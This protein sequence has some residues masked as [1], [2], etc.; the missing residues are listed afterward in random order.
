MQTVGAKRYFLSLAFSF[1]NSAKTFAA[2][3]RTRR[4]SRY[5]WR[6]FSYRNRALTQRRVE[7]DATR[8]NWIRDFDQFRRQRRFAVSGANPEF[9]V[10]ITTRPAPPIPPPPPFQ[11]A[12]KEAYKCEIRLFRFVTYSWF[13]LNADTLQLSGNPLDRHYWRSAFLFLRKKKK[14]WLN[15]AFLWGNVKGFFSRDLF[16]L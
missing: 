6:S 11:P 15:F 3:K 9:T 14:T 1:R 13:L 16:R 5:H 12:R 10:R 2:K 7:T 4:H 8:G